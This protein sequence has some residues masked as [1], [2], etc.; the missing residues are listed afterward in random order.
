VT[1]TPPGLR[2]PSHRPERY[3]ESC[4][5]YDTHPRHIHATASGAVLYKHMDCCDTDGCPDGSCAQALNDSGGARGAGL[6]AFLEARM[7]GKGA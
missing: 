6:V 4:R 3:C 2:D 5:A 1:D 7:T